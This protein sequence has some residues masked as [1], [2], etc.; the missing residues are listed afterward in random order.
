MP[1]ISEQLPNLMNGVSQQAVTMRMTSQGKAQ[2]NALSSLLE[3]NVK[4]PPTKHT[5][6]I[7]GG[8]AAGSYIHTINRDANEQYVV[9]AEDRL[10]RVFDLEGNEKVVTYPDGTDYIATTAPND[11]LRAVTVADFTFLVN[12][13]VEVQTLPDLTPTNNNAAMGFIKSVDYD[14]TYRIFV[15]GVEHAVHTTPNTSVTDA[16][17]YQH[18][19]RGPQCPVD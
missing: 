1:L 12:R 15:D 4:R 5:T 7:S 16:D 13:N 19:S 14:I 9:L 3:G 18:S 6:K 2:E 11:D 10:I 17:L 8:S